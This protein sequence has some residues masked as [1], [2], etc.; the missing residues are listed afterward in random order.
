[1]NNLGYF[2]KV[3]LNYDNGVIS[4]VT[5][6]ELGFDLARVPVIGDM[7]IYRKRRYEVWRVVMDIDGQEIR[8]YMKHI[9]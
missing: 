6:T 2:K 5:S 4:G 7:I 9:P 1:M 3:I 8:V